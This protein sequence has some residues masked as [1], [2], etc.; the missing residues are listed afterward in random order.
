MLY[1]CMCTGTGTPQ[2]MS[3]KN[4]SSTVHRMFLS[5]SVN[6]S[7]ENVN[8]TARKH[9]VLFV[10]GM[11][12]PLSCLRHVASVTRTK[13]SSWSSYRMKECNCISH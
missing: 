1:E 3:R 12:P 6:K 13:K 8:Q 5:P 9:N 11:F 7:K 10:C 2:K 4:I